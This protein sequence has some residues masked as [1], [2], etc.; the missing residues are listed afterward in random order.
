[1]GANSLTIH[2]FYAYLQKERNYS[3]LTCDAYLSDLVQYEIFVKTDI[4][5][6]VPDSK[7]VR[8]WI[9]FL[10]LQKISAKSIHRKVSS[11]RSFARFL[12]LKGAISEAISIEVQLP[13]VKKRIPSFVKV[14]EMHN[15]LDELESS[16]VDYDTA[17]AFVI[18]STFYHT[19]VRRSELIGLK[20][21]SISLSNGEMKVLGKG[22]KERII[23]F[24]K[25]LSR[26]LDS[27]LKIK[28]EFNVNTEIFFCKFDGN[29][30]SEKWLYNLVNKSLDRTHLG[31][32]SPHILRH[33]FATHLLQNG[34]DINAIKEL[35][36]HS[37]LGATQIYTHNDIGQ[38][39][40]VYKNTHPFSD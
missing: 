32:R 14:S 7:S 8:R 6:L 40:K 5:Q 35:L 9:R 16:V 37:S 39:K 38:L 30:L 10:S 33:T 2:D 19:G 4:E 12:F 1:M 27:F 34:A 3:L 18:I 17:L 24:G 26:Q 25:E 23:P 20:H 28:A 21:A 36:G 29:K 31:K 13:K 15:L 22:R 11:V